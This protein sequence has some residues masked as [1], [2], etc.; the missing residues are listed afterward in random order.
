MQAIVVTCLTIVILLAIGITH[1]AWAPFFAR[2]YRGFYTSKGFLGAIFSPF[3]IW[4]E[5][6]Y[7]ETWLRIAGT[8]SIAM[9]IFLVFVMVRGLLSGPG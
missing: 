3:R 4:V 8:I 6:A 9:A 2:F 1:L 7:Y 5:G